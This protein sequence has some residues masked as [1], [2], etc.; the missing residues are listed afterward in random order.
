VKKVLVT[1]IALFNLFATAQKAPLA[2]ANADH[3]AAVRH[4]VDFVRPGEPGLCRGKCP[5]YGGDIDLNDPN[6]DGFAN[7]NTILVPFTYVYSAFAP[8]INAM[9]TGMV[10]NHLPQVA[11][12]VQY[13][14]AIG[15]YDVRTGVSTGNGGTDVG[16]GQN[17]LYEDLTGRNPFGFAEESV[18]SEFTSPI[19]ITAGTT[20][21]FNYLPQCTASDCDA[22]IYYFESNTDALNGVNANLQPSYEIFLN[23]GFFGYNWVNACGGQNTTKC[24]GMSYALAGHR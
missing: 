14:P 13:D 19:P 4:G 3:H 22:N 17:K 5:F 15:V 11:G 21:W 18:G 7:G 8:P 9:V 6:A 20:Y 1:F 2:S 24:Q 16:T 10:I 23:S 12:G